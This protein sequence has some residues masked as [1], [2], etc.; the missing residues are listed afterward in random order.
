MSRL[1]ILAFLGVP[2]L[3]AC[4]FSLFVHNMPSLMVYAVYCVAQLVVAAVFAVIEIAKGSLTDESTI[5]LQS[6]VLDARPGVSLQLP[7]MR[8]D[9]REGSKETQSSILRNGYKPER[10]RKENAE[11]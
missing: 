8:S 2:A 9:Y 3:V 7:P 5:P 4:L 10:Y 11:V 1:F 6:I